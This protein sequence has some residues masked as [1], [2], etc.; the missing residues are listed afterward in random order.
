LAAPGH[1][2]AEL[3]SGSASG[4]LIR[5]T[6][7]QYP[8][9]VDTA[10]GEL[11]NDSYGGAWGESARRDAFLQAYAVE[12]A[13]A[14]ARRQG[15]RVTEQALA[16]GS[17]RL[18]ITEAAGRPPAAGSS[19]PNH[20][21]QPTPTPGACSNAAG[22]TSPESARRCAAGRPHA[23]PPATR[24]GPRPGPSMPGGD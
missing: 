3:D 4:L 5:L 14:E 20:L 11:R 16:D 1:D 10:T 19:A 9:V 7:W 6:G 17:V 22:P 15:C 24:R 2:T 18:H 23:R 13:K 21:G 12:K 8:L